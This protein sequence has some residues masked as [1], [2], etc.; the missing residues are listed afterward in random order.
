MRSTS[1]GTCTAD[2][3]LPARGPRNQH[4]IVE[5]SAQLTSENVISTPLQVTSA[6]EALNA[7]DDMDCT[8]LPFLYASFSG[9]SPRGFVSMKG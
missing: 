8:D 5:L 4:L 9:Y 1:P 3:P 2:S 7:T 6:T